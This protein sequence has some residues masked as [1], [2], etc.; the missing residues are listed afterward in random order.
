MSSVKYV[1][2][3]GNISSGLMVCGEAPGQ[4]EDELGIPFVG[5]AGKL[6][7]KMLSYIDLNR[8]NVYVTN[9]IKVRPDQNRRP[10]P[11][12]IESW[13]PILFEEIWDLKPRVI[14]TVGASATSAVL[15]INAP[16]TK[17]R[18]TLQELNLYGK[19]TYMIVPTL[20]PSYLLRNRGNKI[21]NDQVKSDLELVKEILNG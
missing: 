6:L 20:H 19:R 12:E 11:E 14:L 4:D 17:I 21:L 7:D 10:T 8:D 18:G 1:H 3:S 16:I 5:R 15:R 2:P 9:I 13:R